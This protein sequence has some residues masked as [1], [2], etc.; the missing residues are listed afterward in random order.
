MPEERHDRIY[1]RRV[2]IFFNNFL[3]GMAWGLGATIGASLFI[4]ILGFIAAQANLVPIVGTFVSQ[5]I[6]FVL[7]HNRMVGK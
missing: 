1:Q 4:T 7:T 5:I 6:D 2:H 3:G